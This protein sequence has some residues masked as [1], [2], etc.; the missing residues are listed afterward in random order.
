MA[1]SKQVIFRIPAIL[2]KFMQSRKEDFKNQSGYI[3]ELIYQDCLKSEFKKNV[4]DK[5]KALSD[6]FKTCMRYYTK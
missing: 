5:D 2:D 3:N 6:E 1:N 4:I